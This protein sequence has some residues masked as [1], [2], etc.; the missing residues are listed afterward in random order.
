M[1][2]QNENIENVE[3]TNFQ[4]SDKLDDTVQKRDI[5]TLNPE[6]LDEI[7]GGYIYHARMYDDYRWE[8]IDINGQVVSRYDSRKDAEKAAERLGYRKDKI[9]WSKLKGIRNDYGHGRD[10]N[11]FDK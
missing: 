10:R 8:L 4:V 1:E 5:E 9:S 11:T 2:I 3:S 6:D 7:S